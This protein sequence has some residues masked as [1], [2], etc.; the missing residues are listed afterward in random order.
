VI[1]KHLK[2]HFRTSPLLQKSVGVV[3]V[4]IIAGIGVQLLSNSHASSPYVAGSASKGTLGGSAALGTD[5]SGG[6]DI[7]FGGTGV[8]TIPSSITSNCSADVSAALNAWLAS[9]PNG[10]TIDFPSGACYGIDSSLVLTSRSNLTING[11]GGE[12]EVLN[13][14]TSANTSATYT[15]VPNV[16][17]WDTNGG[18]NITFENMTLI[19]DNP[20]TDD[21][22]NPDGLLEYSHGINFE[23]VN[24]GAVNNVNIENVCGDFVEFEA[25]DESAQNPQWQDD[26]T[27]ITITGGG[28][29]TSGRQGIGI[30]D[31][32]NITITGVTMSGVP[33]DAIDIEPDTALATNSNIKI[34]N[35]TFEY[36]NNYLL[37][38]GGGSGGSP[39]V[40]S[41][42]FSG[43]TQTHPGSC[44]ASVYAETPSG[45]TTRTNYVITNNK[46]EPYTTLADLTS[47]NDVTITNNTD[48]GAAGNGGCSSSAGVVLDNVN[49]ASIYSNDFG[50]S[51]N[52]I[53]QLTGGSALTICSN[54]D[55]ETTTF[56]LPIVCY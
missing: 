17:I 26:A 28:F 48:S 52:E 13:K 51:V 14:I 47:V 1:K 3:I 53:D 40:G 8:K 24:T 19:G 25:F 4:I 11:N 41:I 15:S 20:N 42:T 50:S 32:D 18:S 12:V 35:N 2:I 6:S 55:S 43:N 16:T 30:T 45:A 9:V 44:S 23:G 5:S 21:L 22:C 46:L 37:A 27:N 54:K 49:T 36:I 38:N 33:E 34:I 10:S 56:N 29:Y 7:V 31:A 39:N